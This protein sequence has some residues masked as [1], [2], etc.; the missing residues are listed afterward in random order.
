MSQ[1]RTPPSSAESAAGARRTV[2]ADVRASA[3]EIPI[4]AAKRRR[5][6]M[7]LLAVV[8]CFGIPLLLAFIWL[9]VVQSGGAGELGD[10]SRGELIRPA[11]PI[12]TFALAD[13]DG[14]AID[15]EI[16]RGIWTMLYVPAGECD[17]AC[18]KN[19]YHMRQ[20]RLALNHRMKRVQRLVV[21][22]GAET[23][24]T[25]LLAEHPGL[26]LADG[27]EEE[28][29]GFA[30]QIRAAQA[31]MSP[32]QDAIFLVDPFGNLMMRFA[33]ELPPQ[34]MLK[35]I[36]HLLKKSKIG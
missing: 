21:P 11:V 16:F 8:A 29:V 5:S 15:P 34:D 31:D 1:T 25:A 12:E 35:D 27:V 2:V 30:A 23:L 28:R 26:I 24:P 9:R 36:K 32:V 7:L 6:R 18:E 14:G 17:D 19:L 33:P 22:A 20:V 3:E 10:T 13:V 4:D